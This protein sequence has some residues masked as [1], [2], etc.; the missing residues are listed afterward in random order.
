MQ[1]MLAMYRQN[2]PV[3]LENEDF[4]VFRND[5]ARPYVSANS[6]ACLYIGDFRKSAPLALALASKNF[7]LV[8]GDKTPSAGQYARVYEEGAAAFAPV[9]ES[10]AVMLQGLE[11]SRLDHHHIVVKLAV[12][13][14]CVV[15]IAESYYPFWRAEVD[16]QSSNVL[17]VDCGL[18]GVEV[19]AGKHEIRLTYQPPRRYTI[20]IAV[21]AV[22][23]LVCLVGLVFGDRRKGGL[24]S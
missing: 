3:Q 9:G 14:H 20:A 4:V 23:L 7:T 15:I 22:A 12:P 5:S 18:M 21:S 8:Q 16:G 24:P 17:R 11:V 13:T 2:F 10:A 1:Q 6:R 19:S